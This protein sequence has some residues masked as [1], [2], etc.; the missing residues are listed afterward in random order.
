M[1][2]AAQLLGICPWLKE[3]ADDWAAALADALDGCDANTPARAAMFLAQAAHESGGFRYL[4]E[5]M[6]YTAAQL[7]HTWPTRF[8]MPGHGISNAKYSGNDRNALEYEHQPERIANAVYGGREGNGPEES[9]DGWKYRAGGFG[10]TFKNNYAACSRVLFKGDASVLLDEPDLL[11]G[12]QMA[13][14]SFAWFWKVNNL[15]ASADLNDLDGN[16]DVL[17]I[18]RKTVAVGDAIGWPD[19]VKWYGIFSDLLGVHMKGQG[20][21]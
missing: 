20:N 4:R 9:G 16:S 12:R 6:D 15:N 7:V 14:F 17:N 1:I 10:I 3:Y 19:R 8:Y 2:T 13:A 21:D 18:G 5:N 11:Q